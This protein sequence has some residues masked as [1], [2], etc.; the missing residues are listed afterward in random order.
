MKLGFQFT[1]FHLKKCNH[2][3]QWYMVHMKLEHRR[4][5]HHTQP[6]DPRS[7]CEKKLQILK[8]PKQMLNLQNFIIIIALFYQYTIGS[9][10]KIFLG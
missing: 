10:P 5:N 3:I 7:P 6:N 8:P 1:L 4:T 2:F 9:T